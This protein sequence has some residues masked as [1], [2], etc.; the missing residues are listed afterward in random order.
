LGYYNNIVAST[1]K[2]YSKH[3]DKTPYTVAVVIT[4]VSQIMLLIL[5]FV[6]S[7]KISTNP[8][9]K[10]GFNTPMNIIIILAWMFIVARIYTKNKIN[11]L[12]N[13]FNNKPLQQRRIWAVI[14]FLNLVLPVALIVLILSKK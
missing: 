11:N 2:F 6:G 1:Y 14:T 3:N 7:K 13:S 4:A 9:A 8:N 5:A 10:I 12:V